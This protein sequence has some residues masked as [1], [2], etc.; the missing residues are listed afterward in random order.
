VS[1]VLSRFG[2]T[3]RDWTSPAALAVYC[4]LSFL[5]FGLRL[6][7]EPG[8]QYIGPFDDP[9]IVIWAFGW[10]PHA[11]LHGENPLVTPTLWAPVGINLTWS[12]TVPGLALLVAPL[13]L[14]I[15]P[16]TT[17]N[18]VAILLPAL[19]GWTAFLLCRHLTRSFWPS[20]VGGYLF[21][22]SS[23]M[24]GHM[25]GHAHMTSV[26]LVP[27]VALVVLRY[28]E[29][30]LDGRGLVVRL[31]PLLA[32]QLLFSTELIFTLTLALGGA[33]L[34]ALAL[35]PDRRPRLRSAIG[36][37]VAAYA[38][39]GV[40]TSPFLYYAVKG[41][42]TSA[43]VPPEQYVADLLN[44]FIP[45]NLEL[46]G[47]GWS[48]AITKHFQGNDTE[49]GAFLGPAALVIVAW[50]AW[51]RWRTPGCRFLVAAFLLAAFFALGSEL[52]VAGH[53]VIPLPWAAVIH[54]PLWDN[55]LT[56]RFAM[57]VSLA[58]GVIAALWTAARPAGSTLRWL[59]PGLAMLALVPNPWANVWATTYTIPSFFTDSAYRGCLKPGEI[60][61]PEPISVGG[62]SMLWQ[63]ANGFHFRMAGGRIQQI[64]PSPFMH[65]DS[66]ALISGGYDL[67]PGQAG[68]VRAYIREKGVTSIVVDKGR[69]AKW[70]PV[71]DRIAKRQDVGGVYLYRISGETPVCPGASS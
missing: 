65:P 25:Q 13:T 40:L 18:V 4:A 48:H 34:L 3:R 54:Q 1:A 20:F 49:N 16:F 7:L 27:L 59:L 64:P 23:Y 70:T 26:F 21:G 17:Y 2:S 31:G 19:A 6:L 24:F 68:L 43:Y 61:L 22:F 55:V 41:L 62:E 8:S 66:I 30:G 52:H 51:R 35:V 11:I 37:V 12:T 5:Y 63:V 53:R 38:V 56:V 32:L 60:I 46:P 29:G 10:F 67:K 50:F 9:Q 57:Y 69:S 47:E 58:L 42:H 39:A 45:T 15:G 28:V 71:L 36:P 14:L 33:L 44:F